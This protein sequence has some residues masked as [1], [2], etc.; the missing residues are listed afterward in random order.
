MHRQQHIR[1]ACLLEGGAPNQKID[2]P[3]LNFF[4]D[5]VQVVQSVLIQYLQDCDSIENHFTILM[6][7]F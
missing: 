1:F 2:L 4:A 7:L 5:T 6:K 3:C